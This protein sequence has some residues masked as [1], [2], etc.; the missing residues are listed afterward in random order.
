MKP[1]FGVRFKGIDTRTYGRLTVWH[2]KL[3]KR[4]RRMCITIGEELTESA[5]EELEALIAQNYNL[6]SVK[7]Q[8]VTREL[9]EDE[10]I[11]IT[12]AAGESEPREKIIYGP[13]PVCLDVLY[14]KSIRSLT[15]P[16]KTIGEESDRVTFTGEI[17][18]TEARDITSRK[19]GKKFHII[20]FS[21]TDREDSISCQ[22]FLEANEKND[23]VYSELSG[24]IKK[25]LHVAVRGRAKHNDYAG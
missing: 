6:N 9:P 13:K 23:E 5:L 7:I 2:V 11:Y 22:M 18:E 12:E 1:Q 24:K 10:T 17:F 19:T 25:K 3:Y 20:T 15:Q 8:T 21:V 16:I 4:R 14:G